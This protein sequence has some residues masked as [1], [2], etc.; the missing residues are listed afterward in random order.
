MISSAIKYQAKPEERRK[1]KEKSNKDDGRFKKN[2]QSHPFS[3]LTLIK[4]TSN[5]HHHYSKTFNKGQINCQKSM[6]SALTE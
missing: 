5:L 4:Q 2:F 6:K 1:E 3:T